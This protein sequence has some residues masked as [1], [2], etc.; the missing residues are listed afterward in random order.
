[1]EQNVPQLEA[2][3]AEHAANPMNVVNIRKENEAKIQQIEK[4]KKD[5]SLMLKTTRRDQGMFQETLNNCRE[6]HERD[7][8]QK[9]RVQAEVQ[10]CAVQIRSLD[11]STKDEL[12]VYGPSI[13]QMLSIFCFNFKNSFSGFLNFMSSW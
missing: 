12:A 6:K 7:T 4:N 2:D 9:S 11:G 13:S 1:M 3:I 8:T 10:K 5:V